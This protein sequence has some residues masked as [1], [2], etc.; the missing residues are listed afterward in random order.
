MS[1]DRASS[2]MSFLVYKEEKLHSSL[3]GKEIKRTSTQY[4]VESVVTNTT[5]NRGNMG[6]T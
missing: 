1:N 4:M 6:C 5:K 3:Q 2:Y